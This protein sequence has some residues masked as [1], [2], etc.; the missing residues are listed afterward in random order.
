MALKS[1]FFLWGLPSGSG[2]SEQGSSRRFFTFYL[3]LFSDSKG[4]SLAS[5]GIQKSLEEK[6][7]MTSVPVK[8]SPWLTGEA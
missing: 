2:V 5:W 7:R 3:K 6:L 1:G 8:G 4:T